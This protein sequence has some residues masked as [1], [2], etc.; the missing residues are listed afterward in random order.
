MEKQRGD[1]VE[2]STQGE[3]SRRRKFQ[4]KWVEGAHAAIS[5]GERWCD[6]K[7]SSQELQKLGQGPLR[8]FFLLD[9]YLATRAH[10]IQ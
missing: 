2:T 7:K 3:T 8:C 4:D 1:R 10:R 5:L 6:V 9:H